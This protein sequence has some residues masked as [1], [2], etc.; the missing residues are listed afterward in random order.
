MRNHAF[1]PS[2]KKKKKKKTPVA[3]GGLEVNY[4]KGHRKIGN[5]GE[6]RTKPTPD[7]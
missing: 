4:L 3:P 7:Q 1:A 2:A 5:L 6:K